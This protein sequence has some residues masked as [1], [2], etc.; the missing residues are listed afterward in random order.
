MGMY[1]NFFRTDELTVL[2]LQKGKA[3]LFELM[4][5]ENGQVRESSCL[6]E[7]DKAWHAIHFTLS[8]QVYE[9][10]DDPLS[11]VVLSPNLVN[12]EDVAGYGPAMLKTP[13]EVAQINDALGAVSQQWFAERFS[14][15][16]MLANQVYPI[17]SGEDEELFFEY[18]YEQN[19]VPLKAFYEE[20]AKNGQYV[21]FCVI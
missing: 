5:D 10:T 13:K 3:N 14:L 21:L 6:F 19:F 16:E 4:Y 9:S 18:V 12:D 7:V 17:M 15:A 20:A 11:K 1:G 8:G 2:R